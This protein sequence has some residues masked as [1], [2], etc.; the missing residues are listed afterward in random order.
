MRSAKLLSAPPRSV[1]VAPNA[2][3]ETTSE[4]TYMLLGGDGQQYGPVTAEQ[5]L[6]WVREGRA[7][8]QT[9]IL[10]SD[11]PEWRAA[12]EFPELNLKATPTPVAV[13]PASTPQFAPATAGDP[14]LD[15]RIRSGASWFYW[16]A[17][18]SVINSILLMTNV[19]FGFAVGLGL[20]TITD[21]AFA[22][23]PVAALAISI[24]CSAV[25]AVFGYF[26]IKRH[27][28]AFIVGLLVLL[29]DTGLCVL[30][31]SWISVAFHA[32]AIVSIFMA[33]RASRAAKS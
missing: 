26:S 23:M 31:K 2:F 15:A 27:S 29:L 22:S 8:G 28:W 11:F 17:A 12:A 30:I 19:G 24:V 14:E 1:T 3:M 4:I 10:R 32:W 18:L 7:N 6:T 9:Q 33:F 21:V 16:V 13:S 20:T 25:I 5:F